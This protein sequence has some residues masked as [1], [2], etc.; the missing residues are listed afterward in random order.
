MVGRLLNND[1]LR[2]AASES[3]RAFAVNNLSWPAIA[4]DLVKSLSIS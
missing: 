2:K 1:V 4:A 3:A